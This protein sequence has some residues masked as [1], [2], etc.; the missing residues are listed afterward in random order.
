MRQILVAQKH[1]EH[2]KNE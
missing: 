2:L 1:P